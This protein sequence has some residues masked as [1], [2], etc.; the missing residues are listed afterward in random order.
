V[1]NPLVTDGSL[2]LRVRPSAEDVNA[3]VASLSEIP[4][5]ER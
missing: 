3:L 5:D 1:S 2:G 4:D